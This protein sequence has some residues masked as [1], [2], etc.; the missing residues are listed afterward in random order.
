M[1]EGRACSEADSCGCPGGDAAR[2]GWGGQGVRRMVCRL[3]SCRSAA[4]EAGRLQRL[5]GPR[6]CELLHDVGAHELVVPALLV[7]V[8]QDPDE[9]QREEQPGYRF[10]DPFADEHS[11]KASACTVLL[12]HS[13]AE[14]SAVYRLGDKLRA[15]Q[16]T[17]SF[18]G[19]LGR[20]HASQARTRPGPAATDVRR[21]WSAS[22]QRNDQAYG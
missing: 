10:P 20:G 15:P 12:D 1:L 6:C 16:A 13:H 19:L 9:A 22:L 3:T 2:P 4:G 11:E 7:A 14:E 18:I 21:T 8:E 5:V 17:A